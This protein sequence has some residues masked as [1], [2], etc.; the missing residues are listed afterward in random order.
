MSSTFVYLSKIL[1]DFYFR[2]T[3]ERARTADYLRLSAR[4]DILVLKM[5]VSCERADNVFLLGD[6]AKHLFRVLVGHLQVVGKF[7]ANLIG[8][9][10]KKRR[11]PNL[12]NLVDKRVGVKRNM[13]QVQ[14]KKVSKA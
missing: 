1:Y 4:Q 3:A 10:R 8:T 12:N 5:N 6:Y 14:A 9:A 11:L 7:A 13:E 2:S